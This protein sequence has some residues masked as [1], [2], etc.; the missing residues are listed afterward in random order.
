MSNDPRAN[1]QYK[2]SLLPTLTT[3]VKLVPQQDT[4][5]TLYREICNGWRMLTDVRFKLLGFIPVISGVVLFSLLSDKPEGPSPLA[6]MGIALFGLLITVALYV[7][8]KRNSE[9][10][11]DLISRGR[12]IEEELG[13]DTGL[14]RGRRVP[15]NQFVKHDIAINLIYGASI[16]AWLV[17]LI[18]IGS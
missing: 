8:E 10:Y 4:L 7:Y 18:Y 17:S 1:R 11:D 14:F 2:T 15:S 3:E 5:F 16:A 12:K 13:I 9:L 6:R